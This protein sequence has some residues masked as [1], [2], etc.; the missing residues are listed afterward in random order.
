MST[1]EAR[2]DASFGRRGK[3]RNQRTAAY[4]ARWPVRLTLP[5]AR[6]RAPAPSSADVT[7]RRRPIPQRIH[8]M[9]RVPGLLLLIALTLPLADA[10]AATKRVVGKSPG[11]RI[12]SGTLKSPL[13]SMVSSERDFAKLAREHGTRAAFLANLA[14]D[15]VVFSPLAVNG[16]D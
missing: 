16:H 13:Q 6:P 12:A 11:A 5:L 15:G 8:P 10:A 1:C 4:P 9:R 3:P 14:A 7:A 2:N